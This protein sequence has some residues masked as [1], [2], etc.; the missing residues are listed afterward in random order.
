MTLARLPLALCMGMQLDGQLIDVHL[1]L[2]YHDLLLL[3]YQSRQVLQL[4]Q[5]GY[6]GSERFWLFFPDLGC[7]HG[8]IGLW[9]RLE[10]IEGLMLREGVI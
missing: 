2:L 7:R 1:S 10:D 6:I 8:E 9:L 5:C 4:L 3:L